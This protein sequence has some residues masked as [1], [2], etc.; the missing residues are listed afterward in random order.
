MRLNVWFK[1]FR[2]RLLLLVVIPSVALVVASVVSFF[3]FNQEIRDVDYLVKDRTPKGTTIGH[4]RMN[5]YAVVRYIWAAHE[6]HGAVRKS[7]VD[8]ASVCLGQL[9]DDFKTLQDLY[10]NET[11]PKELTDSLELFHKLDATMPGVLEKLGQDAPQQDDA[12]RAEIDTKIVSASDPLVDKLKELETLLLKQTGEKTQGMMESSQASLR[13]LLMTCGLSLL[14][15]FVIG[16]LIA[17]GL[18]KKFSAIAERMAITGEQVSAGGG[19]LSI[20]AGQVSASA[21]E[22]AA[23]LEETVASIEELSSMVKLNADNAKQAA[24][25]AKASS[26]SAGVGEKEIRTLIESMVEISKGSK[27]IEEIISVIDDI[28]FQ[29]NI[30]ALNAAV[31]AARAGEQGKGFAVVAEAVRNLAQ[32]S[33]GAAK[34]ITTLIGDSVTKI[35]NGSRVADKSGG[36]LKDI[37]VSIQKVSELN[38]EISSASAEQSSGISQISQ[39]IN[40]L[41]QVTQSNASSSQEMSVATEQVN[42]QA[43]ALKRMVED[44]QF[45]ID[46]EHSSGGG[47]AV[48]AHGLSEQASVDPLPMTFEKSMHTAPRAKT[49]LRRF[50]PRGGGSKAA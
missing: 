32:R 41:D 7:K 30:L 1:A 17:A 3:S 29:T 39:A 14:A 48:S 18:A 26:E 31:E 42:E 21:T 49:G 9:R 28:A 2:L 25:L 19:E 34:E 24:I 37:V 33:A 11:P 13:T 47:A 12:L 35:E 20:A 36:V 50:T 27:K 10:R 23:S 6:H 45:I 38:N 43:V 40:Q 4:L 16:F 46:G 15:A 8:A 5:N 44:L 22:S